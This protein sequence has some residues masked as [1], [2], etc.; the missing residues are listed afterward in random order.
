C[1]LPLFACGTTP[2]PKRETAFG[3][4]VRQTLDDKFRAPRPLAVRF[5]RRLTRSVESR[6]SQSYPVSFRDCPIAKPAQPRGT[7]P[8]PLSKKFDRRSAAGSFEAIDSR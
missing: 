3:I 7:C 6:L 1:Q 8:V 4:S 2:S 5:D